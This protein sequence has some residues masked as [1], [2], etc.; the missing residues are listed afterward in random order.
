MDQQR[1]LE[2]CTFKCG[3]LQ[4]GQ[5]RNVI[6]SRTYVEGT[7]RTFS[8][9]MGA[10]TKAEIS[11]LAHLRATEAGC[12]VEVDYSEG[13]PPVVNNPELFAL[14]SAHVNIEELPEPL[15][16]AEDFAFYQRHLPGVFMLLGTGT[17]TPLHADTFT[18]DESILV[19]GL[20]AYKRLIRIP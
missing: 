7:L 1:A 3:L 6:S 2:P 15:L 14:A 18:F 19:S 4:S 20:E 16:I 13:Y 9:E 5:A 17:T 12:T 10:K 8:E 11:R